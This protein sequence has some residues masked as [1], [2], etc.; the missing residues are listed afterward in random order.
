MRK[1]APVSPRT[2]WIAALLAAGLLGMPSPGA[3]AWPDRPITLV[4]PWAKGGTYSTGTLLA[5]LLGAELG[6]EVSPTVIAG[7]GGRRGHDHLKS[8]APDGSTL[9]ILFSSL[10]IDAAD[11][12]EA[13][14][15][16]D[17]TLI[18]L[19][20]FDPIAVHVSPRFG[21][22]DHAGL[23]AAASAHPTRFRPVRTRAGDLFQ[24][25]ITGWLGTAGVATDRLTWVIADSV[26]EGFDLLRSHAADLAISTLPVAEMCECGP[27]FQTLAVF[28]DQR[29]PAFPDVPTAR[30][31]GVDWSIA[32]WR[33]LAGPRGLAPAIV[34]MLAEA[35]ETVVTGRAFLTFF[36]D[37]GFGIELAGPADF[38]A[39]AAAETRRLGAARPPAR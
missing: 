30:E 11:D 8:A 34:A 27:S 26:V 16:D 14:A 3:A 6:V 21:R 36:S 33:G 19:Y 38:A 2:T 35:M 15:L 37:H 29:V 5:R 10:L 24:W 7:D 12:P 13:P 9:G 28:A 25:A 4:I 31:F 23:I 18:T 17:F 39:F 32:V 1:S 20:N 22:I